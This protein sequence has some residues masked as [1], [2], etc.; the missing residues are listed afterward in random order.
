[1]VIHI[2]IILYLVYAYIT[3]SRHLDPTQ[4]LAKYKLIEIPLLYIV[5]CTTWFLTITDVNRYIFIPFLMLLFIEWA[6]LTLITTLKHKGQVDI[7]LYIF[8]LYK[9]LFP[10]TLVVPAGTLI[11]IIYIL[12]TR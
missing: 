11:G 1:M 5:I 4:A 3:I 7:I 10:Y 9:I 2:A 8:N 6:L 12:C